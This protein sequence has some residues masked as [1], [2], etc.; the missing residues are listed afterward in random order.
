MKKKTGF[1]VYSFT[2]PTFP[3]TP[4]SLWIIFL[5][6]FFLPYARSRG[7]GERGWEK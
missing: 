3:T 7:A 4:Y 6:P 2:F 1:Q 5:L